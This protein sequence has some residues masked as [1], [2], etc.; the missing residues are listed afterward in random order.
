MAQP[1][2]LLVAATIASV[3]VSICAGGDL[4]TVHVHATSVRR[5]SNSNVGSDRACV[6]VDDG[7]EALVLVLALRVLVMLVLVL[8]ERMLLLLLRRRSLRE[9]DVLLHPLRLVREVVLVVVLL[10]VLVVVLLVLLVVREG[11]VRLHLGLECARR[12]QKVVV[13]GVATIPREAEWG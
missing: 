6:R 9:G 1:C 11:K 8:R 13:W 12:G 2:L 5:V 4:V 7:N 3:S 10:Q